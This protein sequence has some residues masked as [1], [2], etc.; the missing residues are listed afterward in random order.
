MKQ[1]LCQPKIQAALHSLWVTAVAFAIGITSAA[2][3]NGQMATP[4][5]YFLYVKANAWTWA[6]ANIVTPLIRYYQ[7]PSIPTPK[8]N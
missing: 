2:L 1:F 6:V 4:E 8:G 3:I 5:M 7:T